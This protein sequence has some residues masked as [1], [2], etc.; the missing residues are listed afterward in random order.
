[1]ADNESSW[2]WIIFYVIILLIWLIVL[3]VNAYYWYILGYPPDGSTESS[4][5]SIGT[6]QTLFWVNIVALILTVIFVIIA[7]I[8]WFSY[9]DTSEIINYVPSTESIQY[10]NVPVTR[11]TV[12]ESVVVS[13]PRYV[14]ETQ[15]RSTPVASTQVYTTPVTNLR[16]I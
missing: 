7:L 1:M 11:T 4:E 2:A 16:N 10:K 9:T 5:I 8:Y 13:S 12:G 6:A 14:Y 15:S 3:G